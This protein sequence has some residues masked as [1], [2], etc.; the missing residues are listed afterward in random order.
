MLGPVC[1]FRQEEGFMSSVRLGVSVR[2]FRVSII[3]RL[4]LAVLGYCLPAFA[5][6]TVGLPPF[7]TIHDTLYDDVKVNDGSILLKLPIRTKAGIIPFSYSL[8]SN[9]AIGT[10]T[11]Q[12]I[13]TWTHM[14][15]VGLSRGI[16]TDWINYRDTYCADGTTKTTQMWDYEFTDGLGASHFVL[17]MRADTAACYAES[18]NGTTNDQSGYSVSLNSTTLHPTI[19]DSS[20]NHVTPIPWN[21]GTSNNQLPGTSTLTDSNGNELAFT[22]SCTANCSP[23][24]NQ[25]STTT[26]TDTTGQTALTQTTYESYIQ[27][28]GYYVYVTTKDVHSWTDAAGHQQSYTVNYAPYT[29]RTNFGC[30]APVDQ[31]ATT[32]YMPANIVA[33]DGT[34]TISYEATPGFSGDV[35]GRISKIVFPSGA[36]IQYSYTSGHNGLACYNPGQY[37]NEVNSITVPV[38]TRTLTDTKGIAHKWVYDTTQGAAETVVTDPSGNDT[39]YLFAFENAGTSFTRYPYETQR[40]LYQGSHTSGT[41]METVT[42]C[43]NGNTTNCANP[44]NGTVGLPFTQKDLYTTLAGMTTSSRVTQLFDSY[45]NVTRTASYDF[46]ASTPTRTVDTPIG[47]Y[48]SGVGCNPIGNNINN[49]TCSINTWAGNVGG[50]LVSSSGF[51]Y[52]LQKGNL[53]SRSDQTVVAGTAAYL[54]TGYT[55]NAN[56]TLNQ[57]TDVNGAQ[58]TYRNY[59]CNGNFAQKISE[60]L[61]LSKSM[62]WDCN[63]GV[64]QVSKDENSQPT[65][66]FYFQGSA[67]D[68]YYRP[69]SLTDPLN[70]AANFAY[71]P[72]TFESVMNFG[73]VS[74]S[75]SLTTTDGFGHQLLVQHRQAQGSSSFD[76]VQYVYDANF[77]NS[78]V[79]LP[80]SVAAGTGCSTAT[81]T[82]TYCRLGRPLTVTDGGGGTVSYT[83]VKNDG[84]Q[85]VGPTQI[86]QKQLEYDGLGRLTS[87]CEITSASGSGACGQA[88]SATGFLTKYTYDAL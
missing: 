14:T 86:F 87:V 60:P 67:A 73:T 29:Q 81:T 9:I 56:G 24:G 4:L 43:Y 23:G 2:C 31:P 15:S 46:G 49:R 75:D 25:V 54:N 19:S 65:T 18:L 66:S 74:T 20:G 17:G 53:S 82:T 50:T 13:P 83:Y 7:S 68:P 40:Q 70:N 26:Y 10:S 1:S 22:T 38:L 48:Q 61:S 44:A 28:N 84:L 72:A 85:S 36:S 33:P 55:Y 39:V 52:D 47:S 77:R 79:S 37:D 30:V 35:T 76:T 11:A 21:E 80:C 8:V 63:G 57:V 78:S 41:L 45:G 69:L 32:V 34:Y 3:S 64:V 71:S 42:T 16:K 51:T 12:L 88:N 5:Q 6:T 27:L 58:T 62:T 59:A